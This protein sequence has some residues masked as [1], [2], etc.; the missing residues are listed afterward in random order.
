MRRHFQVRGKVYYAVATLHAPAMSVQKYFT[1][2]FQLLPPGES[3]VLTREKWEWIVANHGGG[4][5]H[6]V[7][8]NRQH[9][10][11][12]PTERVRY[13]VADLATEF[14]VAE[15]TM[16]AYLSNGLCGDPATLR[17]IGRGRNPDGKSKRFEVP[18]P[19]V[20][21]VRAELARG[22]V[23]GNFSIVPQVA[24]RSLRDTTEPRATLG[25]SCEADTEDPMRENAAVTHEI[26]YAPDA[27]H[28]SPAPRPDVPP[29]TKS[30]KPAASSSRR[31]DPRGK[32]ARATPKPNLSSWRKHVR[33]P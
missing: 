6:D 29:I 22:A 10:V 8:S 3:L 17:P 16:R 18:A 9:V 32:L 30:P 25:E 7:L 20:A 27:L 1:T 24:L 4:G 14:H 31:R 13:F 2:L 23:L 12:S 21:A 11:P 15:S 26:H 19:L 33:T 5:L 28:C